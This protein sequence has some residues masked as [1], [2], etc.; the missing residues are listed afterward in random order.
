MTIGMLPV[1]T[2]RPRANCTWL[3][4]YAHYM[5]G[6]YLGVILATAAEITSMLPFWDF[7]V[8]VGVSRRDCA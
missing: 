1:F 8:A 3:P 5:A 6:S 4:R 7:G 2:K